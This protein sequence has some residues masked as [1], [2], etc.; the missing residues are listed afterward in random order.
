MTLEI[1]ETEM[2]N[3][4]HS[5]ALQSVLQIALEA[6]WKTLYQET[7]NRQVD[8]ICFRDLSTTLLLLAYHSGKNL[9]G[10]AQVG[11]GLLA[12]QLSDNTIHLLGEPDTGDYVGQTYFLTTYAHEALASKVD[13][14]YLPPRPR[15]FFVMTDGV[16]DDLYPPQKKLVGLIKPMPHVLQQPQPDQALLDL[17]GYERVGSFDDRTLVVLC[18]PDAMSLS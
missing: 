2:Q 10:V 7:I 15:L 13:T 4:V 12:T 9:V 14:F 3:A 8:G 17:L 11:D 5:D 6:A 18:Q 1:A 16:S